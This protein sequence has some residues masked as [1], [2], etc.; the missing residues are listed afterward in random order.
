VLAARFLNIYLCTKLS[1]ISRNDT[2]MDNK[3]QF[4]LWFSGVRGAMAFALS[5]KSKSDFPEVGP[6]FLVL[7]LIIILFTILYSALF[8]ELTLKKCEIINMCEADNFEESLFK[9]KNCFEVFKYKIENINQKYLMP[10][11]E[12]EYKEENSQI[13]VKLHEM[14]NV[15]IKQMGL[16]N[17]EHKHEN[18]NEFKGDYKKS[19]D[20]LTIND[21]RN[22]Q[23]KNMHLFE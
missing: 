22:I 23:I 5:I 6:I 13:S 2:K 14:N 1:N 21:K 20:D 11:V 4:F 9:E 16:S 17:E 15:N 10:C 19:N 7:T 18:D 3:K 12:R 8:L